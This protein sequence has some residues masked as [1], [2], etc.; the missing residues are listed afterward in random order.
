MVH[1]QDIPLFSITIPSKTQA[2]MAA[3]RPILLGVRGDAREMLERAG[4]GLACEPEQPGDIARAVKEFVAMPPE[5]RAAMG[6]SGASFYRNQLS[7]SVGVQK[8]ERVFQDVTALKVGGALR[9]GP[10]Q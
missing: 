8:F 1:L 6:A 3:G 9:R 10:V 2:Y 7:L 5:S 4:A